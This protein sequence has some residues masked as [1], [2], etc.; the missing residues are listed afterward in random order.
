MSDSVT[1]TTAAAAA[2]LLCTIIAINSSSHHPS[3][4]PNY[5]HTAHKRHYGITYLAGEEGRR[6]KAT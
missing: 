6:D 4:V 3:G 2:A 5:P 1:T